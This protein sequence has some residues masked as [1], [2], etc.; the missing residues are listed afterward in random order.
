[1]LR[2]AP[3]KDIPKQVF[4]IRSWR[5]ARFSE[6]SQDHNILNIYLRMYHERSPIYLLRVAK[7]THEMADAQA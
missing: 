3:L 7:T 4:D 1:M 6:Q 2:K 5:Q